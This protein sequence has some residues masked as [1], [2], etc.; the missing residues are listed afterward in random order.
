[1]YCQKCGSEI[2]D[3][4]VI[5]TNCGCETGNAT[6]IKEQ[7]MSDSSIVSKMDKTIYAVL[8]ALIVAFMFIPKY[9]ERYLYIDGQSGYF[10]VSLLQV[11]HYSFGG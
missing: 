7:I 6:V 3:E 2:A 10:D 5:C 1:M 8:C 4:A 11:L 9:V